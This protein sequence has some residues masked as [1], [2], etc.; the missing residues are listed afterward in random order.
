MGFTI[1]H[2]FND[3]NTSILTCNRGSLTTSIVTSTRRTKLG[4]RD[5]YKGKGRGRSELI[6][7]ERGLSESDDAP[8][9]IILCCYF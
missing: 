2:L 9:M 1:H 6:E 7:L 3:A 8:K 4:T 5:G